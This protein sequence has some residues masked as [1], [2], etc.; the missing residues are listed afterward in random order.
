MDNLNFDY[1]FYVTYYKDLIPNGIN[2]PRKACNHYIAIGIKEKRYKNWEEYLKSISFSLKIYRYNYDDLNKLNDNQLLEHFCKNGYFEKRIG[3]KYITKN[4]EGKNFNL[5]YYRHNNHDINNL[6]D[7]QLLNHFINIGKNEKRIWEYKVYNKNKINYLIDNNY[8]PDIFKKKYPE[9]NNKNDED[10]EKLF[11]NESFQLFKNVDNLKICIFFHI[12]NFNIAKEIL[13]DFPN[14]FNDKKIDLYITYYDNTILEEINK[15][16]NYKH[17]LLVENR[18]MDI[19]GFLSIINY[20]FNNITITYDYFI[21][22]H[23]KTDKEWRNKLIKPIYKNL[24]ND[25]YI[26]IEKE[27]PIIFG[28]KDYIYYDYKIINR[29]YLDKFLKEYY[30]IKLDEL[31]IGI[32]LY[33]DFFYKDSNYINKYNGLDFNHNSYIDL[34]YDLKYYDKNDS[35]N[36]WIR[37]GKNEFHRISNINYI[38]KFGKKYPFIAGTIFSFNNNF[39]SILKK[40][41]FEQ[42]YNNFEKKN[43]KNINN[44]FTHMFEYFFGLI[45][46]LNGGSIIELDENIKSINKHLIQE[47]ILT[48]KT[49]NIINIPFTKAKIAFFLIYV[50][51]ST[52]G[53]YRT[54]LKY[55]NYLTELNYNID[56]YLGEC[57]N[58]EQVTNHLYNEHPFGVYLIDNFKHY[59]DVINSYNEIDIKK[60]NF[61]SGLKLQRDYDLVIANAWQTAECCYLQKHKCKKIVYIIQDLEYL[62]Y[63]NDIQLQNNVKDTYK[64]EFNYYCLSKYLY[65]HFKNMNF[66]SVFDSVLS[67]NSNDYFNMKNHRENS[68]CIAYYKTKE[69]RLPQLVESIILKLY[70]NYKLYIFPDNFDKIKHNNIINL[71]ILSKAQLNELYNKCKIGIVFS[72]SNP[73]RLGFE[74]KA[75]GLNV[76]EY[77]SEFTKYDLSDLHFNKIKNTSNIIDLVNKLLVKKSEYKLEK[78]F[79]KK[80]NNIV[81]RNKF[82]YFISRL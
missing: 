32:K 33:D 25:I 18:G 22:I 71:S 36:H 76:I 24:K 73:S 43:L 62:F 29:I 30:D 66:N 68:I 52:S 2:T 81:E 70:K 75:S 28:S 1:K 56:I 12:G 14:F 80:F 21:K 15:L 60:Y 53:G 16:F 10:L 6:T 77:L 40:I 11:I 8:N 54:L 35:Y 72:N 65:N 20:F 3:N 39:M 23:T 74:M 79:F 58:S 48:N 41:N 27:K 17:I 7:T 38:K 31:N 64:K 78:E 82:L 61:Y 49:I 9:F 59:I 55:I 50:N 45:T 69:N 34:E 13:N 42:V 26:N 63:P 57:W 51:D 19:G 4:I 47:Y 46:L 67:F 37:Y 5:E 44:S